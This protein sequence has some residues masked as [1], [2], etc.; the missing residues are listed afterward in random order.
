MATMSQEQLKPCPFCGG[1]A[2]FNEHTPECYFSKLAD[3]KKAPKGDVACM[4]DLIPAWNTRATQPDHFPESG[5]MIAQPE[6]AKGGEAVAWLHDVI[7]ADGETDHALSFSK[8]SFPLE[9]IGG[10]RSICA[11]PLYTHPAPAA[12]VSVSDVIATVRERYRGT[13]W[14]KA[15]ECICDAVDEAILALRP[16]DLDLSTPTLRE[17]V[18]RHAIAIDPRATLEDMP[19]AL[20]FQIDMARAMLRE[21]AAMPDLRPAQAGDQW[22]E[23]VED[24]FVIDNTDMPEDPREAIKKLIATEVEMALDPTISSAA[25]ELVQAGVP[26][27]IVKDAQRY[28]WLA[29]SNNYYEAINLISDGSLT[30][31]ALGKAID[32]AMAQ[33]GVQTGWIKASDRVPLESDGEVFVRFTDGSVGTAWATYWHGA[34]NGFAQW[35]HPDPEEDRTV[36]YWMKPP[37]LAAAPKEGGAA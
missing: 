7:Q 29:D 20:A 28:R 10:F 23:A 25:A 6:Q 31:D 11:T 33:A 32:A 8:N 19:E 3:V 4:L 18:T 5:K 12:S 37:M 14:G 24:W 26:D 9:G 34:S 17:M 36:A 35:S 15:A 2:E 22:R 13:K 16:M 21:F 30:E 1:R 27:D